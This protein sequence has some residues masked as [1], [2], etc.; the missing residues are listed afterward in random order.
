MEELPNFMSNGKEY[1]LSYRPED[2]IFTEVE[3]IP[4]I[5]DALERAKD[6]ISEGAMFF[7][8]VEVHKAMK[9]LIDDGNV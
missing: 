5:L 6:V 1:H 2:S 7:S 8:L 3:I 4:D 9:G